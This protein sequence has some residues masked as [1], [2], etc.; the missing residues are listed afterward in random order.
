MKQLSLGI[1]TFSLCITHAQALGSSPGSEAE[2]VL[3]ATLAHYANELRD[4][5]AVC[6]EPAVVAEPLRVLLTGWSLLRPNE[7]YSLS[8]RPSTER[9]PEEISEALN[10][11]PSTAIRNKNFRVEQS[12]LR[13][14]LRARPRYDCKIGFAMQP[15][16]IRGDLAVV[17]VRY[18]CGDGCGGTHLIGL[19]RR[20]QGWRAFA[21]SQQI[22]S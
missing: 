5:S 11:L 17:H 8:T 20:E 1:L 14:P 2:L 3:Q 16:A 9:V 13:K 15:P 4:E 22:I 21:F 10:E 18:H 19:R 6:V 12:W 7:H